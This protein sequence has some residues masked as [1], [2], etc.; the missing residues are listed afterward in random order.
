[1]TES[2]VIC[3]MK[4]EDE[5]TKV[6]TTGSTSS[7]SSTPTSTSKNKRTR[8]TFPFGACRVC[9]DSATGIHYGI[10]TCEGCKGFFKR[11]ILRKEKYRCY[12]DN[13]CVINVANRNRCKACRFRR[14]L[15]EGMSVDGVKMGRIP[16]IV[17][18]KALREQQE[19]QLQQETQQNVANQ[20]AEEVHVRESSCSSLSDRSI[21]NY[22][23]NI[24]DSDVIHV[25]HSSLSRHYE[26]TKT[27]ANDLQFYDDQRLKRPRKLSEHDINS[28][29]VFRNQQKYPKLGYQTKYP[30]FLPDN[31]TLDETIGLAEHPTAPLSHDLFQH[32]FTVSSK[33]TQNKSN[34]YINLNEDESTFIRFLRWSSHNVYLRYSGRVKQLETRMNHMIREQINEFPGEYATN[35]EFFRDLRKTLEVNVRMSVYHIQE[36]PGMKNLDSNTL[37]CLLLHR[38]FD[39]FMLKYG[40]LLNKNGQS[41]IVS[42]SGFQF[43]RQWMNSFYGYQ[44]TDAMFEFSQCLYELDLNETEIALVIPLQMLHPDS[45]IQ[46]DEMPRILRSCYLYA[47]YEELCHNRGETEGRLLC[48]KILQTL[49]LL[50]PINEFY[51]KNVGTRIL[52]V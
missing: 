41:Y 35:E 43:T 10:A 7:R 27:S 40:C 34:L 8:L 12:F 45:T 39:W 1:M 48:S 47:L 9:S 23:P 16:K 19:R 30:T 21:E 6:P 11:S 17:K 15:S 31:F 26:P 32:V 25:P 37:K 52:Q 24:M 44:L 38:S 33:L 5:V 51:D 4:S 3:K 14:C 2:I 20:R 46:N 50:V 18:E 13:S 36:L 22:D 42:P 29:S 49:D 28:S